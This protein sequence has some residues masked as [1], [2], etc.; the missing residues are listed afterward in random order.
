ML[1]ITGKLHFRKDEGK[2][3]LQI[4]ECVKEMR[5]SLYCRKL[6]KFKMIISVIII[7][8]TFIKQGNYNDNWSYFKSSVN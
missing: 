1:K 3:W 4:P 2:L 7:S 6:K 8:V 5:A